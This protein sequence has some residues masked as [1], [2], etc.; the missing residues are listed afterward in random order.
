MVRGKFTF[1]PI[2]PSFNKSLDPHETKVSEKT[3]D[4][5]FRMAQTTCCGRRVKC[6]TRGANS[7]QKC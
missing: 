7:S 5:T 6:V 1:L 4:C 3:N 2:S